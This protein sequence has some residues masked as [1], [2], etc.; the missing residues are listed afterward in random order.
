MAAVTKKV[1]LETFLT[2]SC[3]MRVS[4]GVEIHHSLTIF[5]S[6]RFMVLVI[7]MPLQSFSIIHLPMKR[8][9][10][11][12]ATGRSS[13]RP[14]FSG[15][16][17]VTGHPYCP[18]PTFLVH[19]SVFSGPVPAPWSPA[20]DAHNDHLPSSIPHPCR[21]KMTSTILDEIPCPGTHWCLP[22]VAM[23]NIIP[24]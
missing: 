9:T 13:S 8:P 20:L 21:L 4:S 15:R 22:T 2:F 24:K 17:R 1:W 7:S 11:R 19:S 23:P 18:S 6:I 12:P 14:P 10:A 16:F 3:F 5:F